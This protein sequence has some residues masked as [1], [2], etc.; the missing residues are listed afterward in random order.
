[1]ALS[2]LILQGLLIDTVFE[3][4]L[5]GSQR[6]AEKRRIQ[7]EEEEEADAHQDKK[8]CKKQSSKEVRGDN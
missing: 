8:P 7:E 2:G 3:M 6:K 4:L 1:M 5:S